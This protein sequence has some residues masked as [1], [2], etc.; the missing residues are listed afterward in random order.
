MDYMETADERLR[1]WCRDGQRKTESEYLRSLQAACSPEDFEAIAVE[2]VGRA[3]TGD[4]RARDWVSRYLVGI[5][6]AAALK[7]SD[8][9]GQDESGYD[10]V[11]TR[12][13]DTRL[14]TQLL[15][16]LFDEDS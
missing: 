13:A 10:P 2:A 6:G 11:E 15:A 16:G 5:P 7:P 8:L 4:A 12:V 14:T 3:K 9:A 1:R